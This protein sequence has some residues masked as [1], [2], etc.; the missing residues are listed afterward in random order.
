MTVRSSGASM[1]STKRYAVA[2]VLRVFPLQQRVES[3]L[4]IACGQRPPV[5][6]L[7]TAMKM[8]DVSQWIR[9]LPALG[10]PRS[11][12]QVVSTLQ[13]IVK[14]QVVN[15]FRLR[16]LSHPWIKI[17]RTRLNNHDQRVGIGP[18]RA[19]KQR[20]DGRSAEASSQ[21]QIP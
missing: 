4:H 11:H 21:R 7:C 9:N 19:G 5:M 14:D 10:Q 6:K 20:K 18:G 13:Q 16:I 12:I 3:P 15:P 17:R 8:K 1:R 2:L